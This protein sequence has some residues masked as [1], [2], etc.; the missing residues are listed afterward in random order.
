[1]RAI[2]FSAFI[3]VVLASTL[4][5]LS[6]HIF[7]PAVSHTAEIR[8]LYI[9]TT[10]LDAVGNASIILPP[11]VSARHV[12]FTYQVH[13]ATTSM[14]ELHLKSQMIDNAFSVGGGAPG[15]SIVWE[16]VGHRPVD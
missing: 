7:W 4:A 6:H 8:D 13:G 15:A 2:H 10:T 9:G 12:S 3:V 16:V 14:P 1:M 11:Y 5:A